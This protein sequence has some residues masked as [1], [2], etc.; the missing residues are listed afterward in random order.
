MI[1]LMKLMKNTNPTCERVIPFIMFVNPPLV[2]CEYLQSLVVL[3]EVVCFVVLYM[4]IFQSVL[5]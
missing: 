4:R 5:H 3:L 1:E 2:L